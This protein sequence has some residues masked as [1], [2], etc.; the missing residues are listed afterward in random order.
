M[1]R[2]MEFGQSPQLKGVVIITLP[3]PDNPSLGKTIT[4]FTLS[5]PPLDRPHHT[6][7]QLQRQQ[8]QE[9]EEEE[10]EEE[11]HQLPSPSPPN[12]ALQFSVR[13]LSL[14]NP[15]ILMGFLGV[16][17]FV[18]LLWNFASSSPLVELRRK[19]DDRE[20]TSFILPLYPKLGSRSLGDL[21]L[22]L[23]KFVDFHVN[24]MKPGGINKLATSVSAFDSSTIFPVR[25][26]VY[27]NGYV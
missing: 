18:F 16:S 22:K 19:N 3:P 14:G 20:P 13:K 4:A 26:D 27:P 9:E 11:P 17:L 5:D 6:H 25:G 12:P 7:Q 8:H 10:E 24:D 1:Q 23:G 2:D 15:R 21:E